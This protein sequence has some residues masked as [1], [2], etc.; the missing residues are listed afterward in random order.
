MT[1]GAAVGRRLRAIGLFTVLLLVGGAACTSAPATS[2][3]APVARATAT[4][5]ASPAGGEIERIKARGTLV[6]AIRV[7]APPANRAM[8][9]PAHAQK[10][11]FETAVV[12]LI[13]N[14]VFGPGVKVQLQSQGGDRLAAL[15]QT[16]DIAMVTESPTARD[17]AL[18]SS[19]YA[20]NSV[21]VA[22][23]SDSAVGRVEDLAGKSVG[24]AQDELVT[25]D[26]A[27]TFFQQRGVAVT[28]DT[29]MGVSG[30]AT[31]LEAG[32]AAAFV[33]DGIGVAF[34]AADRKLKVVA[35]VGPRPYVIA[36]R[37]TAPDLAKAIDAALADA[38]KSGAIKDAAAKAA[39]PYTAP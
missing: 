17:R 28:L 3:S 19:P 29:Y 10:R 4:A 5:T 18:L 20:A 38:L 33:G 22:T 15:A 8:G 9:D 27:Q 24:V 30:G 2:A 12:M 31:A 7:E 37:Q 11:A 6:V 32:Q 21:V 13:A 14:A 39:F 34:L 35:P 26:V 25:R 23:R 1:T 16:A 36:S